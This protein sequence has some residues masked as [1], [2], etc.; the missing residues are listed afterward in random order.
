MVKC[1]CVS[2]VKRKRTNT[3]KVTKKENTWRKLDQRTNHR[4]LNRNL[5]QRSPISAGVG[6][7]EAD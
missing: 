6:R 7:M 5:T 2:T 4:R 1:W 3:K